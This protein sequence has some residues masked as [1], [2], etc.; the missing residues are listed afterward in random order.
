MK[1]F[2]PP[3]PPDFTRRRKG[4]GHFIFI[5]SWEPLSGRLLSG[6]CFLRPC[7]YPLSSLIS[8]IE[9]GKGLAG[10]ILCLCSSPGHHVPQPRGLLQPSPCSG[11]GGEGTAPFPD[12]L[13]ETPQP[14]EAPRSPFSS[15]LV[16][17]LALLRGW[18]GWGGSCMAKTPLGGGSP[19]LLG[20]SSRRSAHPASINTQ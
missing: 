11:M 20:C 12:P 15:K 7:S 16:A 2:F 6:R 10:R 8:P 13:W 18:R 14:C 3:Q 1:A 17:L 4:A 5:S 19:S 9:R